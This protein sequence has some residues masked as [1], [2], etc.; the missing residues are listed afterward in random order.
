[1][2]ADLEPMQFNKSKLSS[3]IGRLENTRRNTQFKYLGILLVFFIIAVK[4]FDVTILLS[5]L[6]VIVFL[7]LIIDYGEDSKKDNNNEID[8]ILKDLNVFDDHK[9]L[10]TEIE[11]LK[12]YRD[13]LFAKQINQT[14]FNES[15]H[16]MNLFLKTYYFVTVNNTQFNTKQIENARL[17]RRNS[18]NA[19]VSIIVSTK[20]Y[21]SLDEER[22]LSRPIEERIRNASDKLQ[23]IT[24]A[25]VKELVEINNYLH[26]KFPNTENGNIYIDGPQPNDESQSKQENIKNTNNL[27]KHYDL[28]V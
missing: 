3:L 16:Y 20:P 6:V 19:L 9:F 7:Y 1:M 15:L 10:T 11:V 8:Q 5:I 21:Y 24:E 18:L 4:Y 17:Y 27:L 23:E 25:K 2:N 28:F 13:I 14:A 26:N 12:T 22:T